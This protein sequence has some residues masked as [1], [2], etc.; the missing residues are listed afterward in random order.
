MAKN[1]N[2]IQKCTEE[3]NRNFSE[4]GIQVAN[5]FVKRCSI[6]LT[7]R[8]IQIKTTMRYNLTPVRR[9]ITKGTR[10]T[11]VGEDVEIRE[12]LCTVGDNVNWYSHC[13]KLCGGSSKIKNRTNYCM[14]QK[15][16]FWVYMWRKWYCYVKEISAL[17]FS[18]YH[19]SQ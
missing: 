8:E 7:F 14:I 16:D 6:S 4:E 10:E 1:N 9:A 5:G 11:S 18:L 13:G 12:P 15:F 2:S 3:L 19:Y 17:S